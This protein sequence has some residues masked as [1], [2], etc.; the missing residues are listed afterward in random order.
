M[1]R[2]ATL[3]I[4]VSCLCGAQ[5]K[6]ERD[7][8]YEKD[9]LKTAA[10]PVEN[11]AV[12]IP[13]SY[14]LVVGVG[15][16]KNLPAK[17]QLQFAERDAEAIFSI[18]I[19]P[20]GGNFHIE[21]V[22]KL[23]GARATLAGLKKELE[24]WLPGVA[25]DDDRV[26]IYFAGHG[27]VSKGKAYLAPYD[28]DPDN[29]AGTGYPM[30]TLGQVV[31]SKIKAKWKVLLTDSCHSGAITPEGDAQTINR[32]L[33]DLDRS[34]FSLTASRARERSFESAEWGG[35]HGI[36]TYY[37][38][39]GLEGAA[40]ESHDG[41]VT[42]DEL[43]E[44]V[45]RNV[46]EATK[47][48]QNPTSERASYD[49][50][51][52]LA[53]NP[54]GAAPGQ[55]PAPKYGGLVIE[56]N[57]DGV[58]VFVDDKSVGVVAKGTPLRLPGLTPGIHTIKGV[59][60]GFEPDGPRE[61]TVYPGQESTVSLKLLIQRRRPRAA[62]DAFDKGFD[63]YKRGA[64]DKAVEQF[65]K[66][67]KEDANYSQ[68]ALYMA[69]SNRDLF[70]LDEAEKFFKRAI[71]I[72]P[73]YVEA[74]ADYGGMLLDKGDFDESVRQLHAAT[75][76]DPKNSMAFYLLAQALRMKDLYP[77]SIEA[78]RKAIA[79]APN[80]A[81]PYFWLAESLR[82]SGQQKEAVASYSTYLRL[83]D[84]DS[85]LAG[86]LNYYVLG[87]LVGFGKKHKVGRRDVWSDL[88][89]MAYIG[90]CNSQYKLGDFDAAIFNCQSAL[91]YD[92]HDP[93][94]HYLLG[95]AFM[96]RAKKANSIEPLS[97]ARLHFRAML[98]ANADLT[99]SEYARKNIAIIDTL[100]R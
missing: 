80:I 28:L 84:F 39:K 64:Y 82:M 97:A 59:H 18:L 7:L 21:N 91:R 42:A 12:S 79:L 72:D 10:K 81:D 2:I 78:A 9:A 98:E 45:R 77:D 90:L 24:T 33:Q 65:Q 14:A 46:R 71:A 86:K 62:V 25:K 53:Y 52:L 15:N 13:R 19:S 51:M 36:F 4:A 8:K 35:G 66:A 50:N 69:R 76:R 92:S 6:K 61:E 32:S 55:A 30:E 68:A 44:Y 94:A 58:E 20:E 93:Y 60:M 73:D 23:T 22:H 56:T 26:V 89:S 1:I 85:K 34:L 83:S 87:Y 48:Q 41:I 100:V 99:E 74:R 63:Q 37:V 54:S 88:R 11:G 95:L 17:D 47:G 29:I 67:L 3:L 5:Q 43:G 38:V 57:R 70:K 75:Q 27:F 31:G 49:P 96:G 40:D 16:Y